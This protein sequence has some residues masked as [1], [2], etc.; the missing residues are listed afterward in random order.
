MRVRGIVFFLSLFQR[1]S[2]YIFRTILTVLD[3][4]VL[5]SILLYILHKQTMAVL[6][7]ERMTHTIYLSDVYQLTCLI[8]V[9]SKYIIIY[10]CYMSSMLLESTESNENVTVPFLFSSSLTIG[11]ISSDSTERIL[12]KDPKG[13]KGFFF[14]FLRSAEKK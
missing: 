4:L 12:D 1:I 2:Y 8:H 5:F 10:G 13:P 7:W 14:L 11:T 9:Y 6:T 3:F